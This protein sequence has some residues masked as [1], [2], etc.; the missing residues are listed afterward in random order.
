MESKD[1]GAWSC[2]FSVRIAGHLCPWP[3]HRP[4]FIAV[5]QFPLGKTCSCLLLLTRWSRFMLHTTVMPR[6]CALVSQWTSL[7]VVRPPHRR[8]RRFAK[9][10]KLLAVA[11]KLT[12]ALCS[13]TLYALSQALVLLNH[14]L[15]PLFIGFPRKRSPAPPR[16]SSSWPALCGLFRFNLS[17][18]LASWWSPVAHHPLRLNSATVYSREHL[19]AVEVR[20]RGPCARWLASL[21][22]LPPKL[23]LFL[24]TG[25]SLKLIPSLNWTIPYHRHRNTVTSP[26]FLWVLVASSLEFIPSPISCIVL[27]A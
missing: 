23:L 2:G 14:P 7:E 16:G 12:I 24:V 3:R 18:V 20:R 19:L 4:L 27:R 21:L 17:Y 10:A 25:K 11:Y 6:L 1:L 8:P 26:W 9:L 13:Q 15:Y 22:H 5:I